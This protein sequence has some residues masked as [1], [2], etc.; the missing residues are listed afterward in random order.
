MI[1]TDIRQGGLAVDDGNVKQ[2]HR[3]EVEEEEDTE[4]DEPTSITAIEAEL[5][6][7]EQSDR[8]AR[9]NYKKNFEQ[10]VLAWHN[11]SQVDEKTT[12]T[13]LDR[14]KRL[15]KSRPDDW[16]AISTVLD[17]HVDPD[18][19][20]DDDALQQCKAR[21]VDIYMEK[22]GGAYDAVQQKYRKI[23]DQHKFQLRETE[24]IRR[25]QALN[26]LT[27]GARPEAQSVSSFAFE[28]TIR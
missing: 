16:A 11:P 2:D 21:W 6:R 25:V 4:T 19:P 22:R 13:A 17:Q 1:S 8:T 18:S 28:V 9:S 26:A 14:M 23:L 10:T 24:R 5:R 27:P 12:K 15:Q 20:A 7:A 3:S